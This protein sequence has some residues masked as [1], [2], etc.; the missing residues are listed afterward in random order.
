MEMSPSSAAAS[1]TDNCLDGAIWVLNRDAYIAEFS[2]SITF[3]ARFSEDLTT[4]YLLQ[5]ST[6][7]VWL[8]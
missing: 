3:L 6:C 2:C 4:L 7:I 8:V 1:W 5:F